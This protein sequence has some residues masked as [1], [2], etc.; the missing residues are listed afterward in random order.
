[1]KVHDRN[2]NLTKEEKKRALETPFWDTHAKVDK[3][4]KFYKEI[5]K[6]CK[7]VNFPKKDK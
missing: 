3:S 1:M 4:S 5:E 2:M 6:L 7:G